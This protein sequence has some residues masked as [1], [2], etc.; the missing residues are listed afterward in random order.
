MIWI[1]CDLNLWGLGYTYVYG[2]H[3]RS[4]RLLA[5]SNKHLAVKNPA[6]S[7]SED[8]HK[9]SSCTRSDRVRRPIIS[10]LSRGRMFVLELLHTWSDAIDDHANGFR[11]IG[12]SD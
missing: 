2:M 3:K 10:N 1:V 5:Q 4:S 9:V 12:A 8:T 6:T 11:S 7:P